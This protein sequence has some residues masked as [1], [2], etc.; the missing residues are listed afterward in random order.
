[1][2]TITIGSNSYGL[3]ALPTTPA[4]KQLSISMQDA[5][6]VVS[7]PYVPGQFQTQRWPGAD[8]WS[9]EISLPSM[10]RSQAAAW[11]GFLAE[12]RGML[13][14]FQIGD[15]LCTAPQGVATCPN[16]V[17]NPLYNPA[18]E[19]GNTGWQLG[20]GW[21][22]A[23][24]MSYQG[25]WSAA[26]A[27]ATGATTKLFSNSQIACSA[28]QMVTAQCMINTAQ[29]V[30]GSCGVCINWYGP[31]AV[32]LSTVTAP[33]IAAGSGGWNLSSLAASA[34]A[35]TTFYVVSAQVYNQTA[36]TTYVDN[37]FTALA[38]YVIGTSSLAMGGLLYTAG[39]TPSTAGQLLPGDYI[40][41]GYRLYQVCEQVNS[42]VNGWATI[43][44]WPSL[45]EAPAAGTA[46]LLNN[47]QGLFR[48][49][50]PDR[51]V[52]LDD[53]QLAQISFKCIEVR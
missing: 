26:C 39:W 3:V 48:L 21:A 24:G 29:A 37:F 41:L 28:G 38:P 52:H 47:T 8:A 18:F 9:A 7:S 43:S 46:L 25:S 44:V 40:Q 19:L 31:G 2:Q 49:A 33:G 45:R 15:A 30:G 51:A 16:S 20:T 12:L 14:V 53:R 22:I 32:Y 6:A 27:G 17:P 23:P 10:T 4:P 50:S 34:P 42:D 1:M 13:N 11:R 36:G 35:T 5:V